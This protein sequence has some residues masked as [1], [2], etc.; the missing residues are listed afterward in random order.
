M[1]KPCSMDHPPKNLSVGIFEP[2]SFTR[3]EQIW[4]YR[5]LE[6]TPLDLQLWTSTREFGIDL[7]GGTKF[8]YQ[9]MLGNGSANKAEINKGKKI[10]GSLG[11]KTGGWHVEGM[12]QYEDRSEGVNDYIIQGIG[13]YLGE[14]GRICVQY[15]HRVLKHQD[16][17][18]L[19]YN[20][21]S[22]FSIYTLSEKWEFIGRYDKYFGNGYRTMFPGENI[23]YIPFAENAESN[24]FIGAANYKIHPNVWLMPNIK[25][26]LYNQIASGDNP[27]CDLFLNLTLFFR[28]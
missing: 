11:Y 1:R 8:P 12:A 20:V 2:P 16:M 4:G 10:Y 6:K 27:D 17:D 24:F 19:R 14:W 13:A 15:A 18:S 28:Y 21:L 5:P 9:I 3:I 7:S 26:V 22:V 23:A 25:Y